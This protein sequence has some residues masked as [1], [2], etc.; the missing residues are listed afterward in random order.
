M[1]KVVLCCLVLAC[2]GFAKAQVN[3]DDRRNSPQDRY[4]LLQSTSY[5]V[6]QDQTTNLD[7][8][9]GKIFKPIT[10]STV[11]N[12]GYSRDAVWLKFQL[13]HFEAPSGVNW[14]LDLGTSKLSEARMYHYVD[15][16]P[17]E[18]QLVKEDSD[19]SARTV[20]YRQLA[21]RLQM[22]LRRT[23]YWRFSMAGL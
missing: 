12:F 21:F 16:Q 15:G 13:D 18:Q 19:F 6:D 20:P 2:C 11:A 5:W 3:A 4:D 10:G 9:Q 14:Y 8:I 7:E 22:E 23:L 1:F 17:L